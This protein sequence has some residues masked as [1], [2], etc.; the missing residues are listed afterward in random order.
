[1]VFADYDKIENFIVDAE[2]HRRTP[3]LSAISGKAIDVW[4]AVFY[5]L[6]PIQCATLAEIGDAAIT[7]LSKIGSNFIAKRV[8]KSDKYHA[9][10]FKIS[11]TWFP[12]SV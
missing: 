11:P 12:K 2:R 9:E 10:T 5:G 6:W 7:V 3:R 4:V 1:M 8:T